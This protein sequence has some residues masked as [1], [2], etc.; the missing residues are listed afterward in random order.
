M[1]ADRKI[2]D[3]HY[4]DTLFREARSHKAWQERDVSSVIL[5][6]AYDLAK[7]GPTAFNG[8]PMR[9]VFVKTPAAKQKLAPCLDSGNVEKMMTA[10]V[11]AIIAHDLKFHEKLALLAPYANA[12][13]FA[14]NPE[15]TRETAFR[16][17]TLQGAYL[18]LAARSLGLD[19]G[20]MSGFD[21]GRVQEAFF[22]DKPDY[23]VNFLCN[24]GYGDASKL[25]PRGPRLSFDDVCD[26][27]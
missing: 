11:T 12:A 13:G 24:I 18:M 14:A 2:L 20:P 3:D 7:M 23:E 5:Q 15:K 9:V 26:I 27:V 19:C 21:A 10:P 22:A 16:N 1:T 6:A 25:N 8:G 17:G 4:F